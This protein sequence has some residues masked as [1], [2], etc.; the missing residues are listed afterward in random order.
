M[1]YT[2]VIHAQAKRLQEI[3]DQE[4][5]L[6]CMVAKQDEYQPVPFSLGELV[7]QALAA[8]EVQAKEHWIVFDTDLGTELPGIPCY[9]Q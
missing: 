5:D 8:V 3:L 2:R 1:S 4:I 6:F 9:P 7:K